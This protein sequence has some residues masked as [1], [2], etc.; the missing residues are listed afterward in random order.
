MTTNT[1][2]PGSP[3]TSGAVDRV[4]LGNVA[5]PATPPAGA[6]A[7][8]G[9]GT[10]GGGS[11][12]GGSHSGGGRAN[13][14]TNPAR[15]TPLTG[16]LMTDSHGGLVVRRVRVRVTSGPDRGREAL[17]EAGTLLVGTH[18]DNDLVLRDQVVGKYHLELALV[19]AG[20]RV[21][22]LGAE[23]GSLVGGARVSTTVVPAGTEVLLGRTT[24]QL[25]PADLSVPVVQ[26]ERAAFGPVLGRTQPMREMFALL[27]RIAPTDAPV[28]LEGNAGCGKT[29]IAKAMHAASRFAASPM[30][31]LDFGAKATERPAVQ[32]VS[33]RS[34]TFTLV[35]DH[36]DQAP[37]SAIAD[38][39][40][41]YERRE[42]GVLDARIIATASPGLRVAP[43]DNRARRDL[44][45]HVTAVRISVPPLVVRM[46]DVPL[47]V[48]QFSREVC[49]VEPTFE[50]SDFRYVL[51]R[52]YPGD[53]KEL[54][55]MV[56]KALANEPSPRAMLPRAGIAR[57]RA[58]LVLPLNA[59]PKPPDPKAARD[60]LLDAFERDW[61]Q[62]LFARYA[63]DLGEI[64]RETGMAKP[65]VQKLLKKH[66]IGEPPASSPPAPTKR[67]SK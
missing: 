45:A 17:L 44:L 67:A 20:V 62:G 1:L 61:L 5:S 6:P 57:A 56:V 40:T 25:L 15:L 59:R 50:E 11:H 32:H 37:V 14:G 19:A 9:G 46:E 31:V 13:N 4:A 66:G 35:I 49:G 16:V 47:L 65:D 38:L 55:Q 51:A 18:P 34:D 43:G 53:V 36:I 41:L 3:A 23:G 2:L 30:T 60:R 52:K 27:E 58:A 29:L 28:L 7:A 8:P 24:L 33:Q 10:G 21:R 26:S 54:R 39:L 63:G 22:D 48:R 42:E 64:G 12:G